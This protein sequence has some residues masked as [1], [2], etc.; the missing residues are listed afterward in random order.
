MA[1]VS[2]SALTARA[3]GIRD[4]VSKKANTASLVGTL[5]IDMV[6]SLRSE[7]EAIS[8]PASGFV[9]SGGTVG[10]DSIGPHEIRLLTVAG[11]YT[12][13]QLSSLSNKDYIVNV[14]NTSGV[15]VTLQCSGSDEID[16]QTSITLTPNE[17]L[18]LYLTGS[19]YLVL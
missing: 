13:P 3:Q 10:S 5:L 1:E 17:A 15:N 18:T 19:K 9:I 16:D 4:E 11:T 7:Q 12:L 6:D 8:Y 2:K 14:K